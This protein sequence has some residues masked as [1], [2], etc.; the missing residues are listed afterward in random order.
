MGERQE[1]EI[2]LLDYWH[3]VL[4]RRWVV[5]TPLAVVVSVTTLGSFLQRPVYTATTR[6]QIE[7]NTP[8]ILPFQDVM[9]SVP[10]YRNDFYQTQYGLIQSRRVAREAIDSLH[11][12]DLEE[13]RVTLPRRTANGPVPEEQAQAKRIDRFLKMLTVTRSEE[14][15]SE[16]QSPCNL[17]C[18]L[19]L[20]KKNKHDI[21]KH[22]EFYR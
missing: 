8:K 6:L 17:V 10:D 1:K 12:A 21:D 2:H 14:H 7:Q 3:V 19:L 20:E 22:T 15:T 9:S 5:Y 13:F 18:R 4:K 11:L 16:L